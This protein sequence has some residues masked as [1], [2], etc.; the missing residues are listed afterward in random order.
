[1]VQEGAEMRAILGLLGLGLYLLLMT[2]TNYSTNS[3]FQAVL[4]IAGVVPVTLMAFLF[5][6]DLNE[7]KEPKKFA[8]FVT[9]LI[10]LV[11]IGSLYRGTASLKTILKLILFAVFVWLISFVSQKRIRG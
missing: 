5:V 1:M 3:L 9:F 6:D 8:S 10:V 4:F 7:L 2:V 11:L